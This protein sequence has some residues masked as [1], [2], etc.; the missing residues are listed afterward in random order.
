MQSVTFSIAFRVRAYS[1]SFFFIM[2]QYIDFSLPDGKR[3]RN[4]KRCRGIL[5][6]DNALLARKMLLH[7]SLKGVHGVG[8]R[9]DM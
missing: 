7:A 3:E 8:R 4:P 2:A 9:K 5:S 1:Q 6:V